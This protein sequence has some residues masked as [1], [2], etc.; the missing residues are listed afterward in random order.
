MNWLASLLFWPW[1]DFIDPRNGKPIQESF[2]EHSEMVADYMLT[3]FIY[4][5]IGLYISYYILK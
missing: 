4:G 3:D 5:S 2:R 1:L